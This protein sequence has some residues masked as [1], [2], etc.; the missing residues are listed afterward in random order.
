MVLVVLLNHGLQDSSFESFFQTLMKQ[1][2][3]GMISDMQWAVM[4]QGGLNV[5]KTFIKQC[6]MTSEQ[7]MT[8]RIAEN[9]N[10]SGNQS[11]L[12]VHSMQ[13]DGGDLGSSF[14]T[15]NFKWYGKRLWFNFSWS[16]RSKKFFFCLHSSCFF[17]KFPFFKVG[18][19][20]AKRSTWPAG[21][22]TEPLS[23]SN[24]IWSGMDSKA[25]W[26]DFISLFFTYEHNF[27]FLRS[28]SCK[29]LVENRELKV[30][31]V[32]IQ[33]HWCFWSK[34]QRKHRI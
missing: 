20:D 9:G 4:K 18:K 26:L 25:V 14:I 12:S 19:T 32:N 29:K 31:F 27:H 10:L 23:F 2:Q 16:S 28:Q 7:G 8:E 33:R 5:M 22:M 17:Q 24:V 34:E 3:I 6:W 13:S 11:L 21:I 1:F 30:G 15:K